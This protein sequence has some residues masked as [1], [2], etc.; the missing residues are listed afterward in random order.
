MGSC[1]FKREIRYKQV[2]LELDQ[3]SRY[4]RIGKLIIRSKN[5]HGKIIGHTSINFNVTEP[6]KISSKL[7]EVYN[8]KHWISSCVLPGLDPR[9]DCNKPCQDNCVFIENEK[10]I[11][12]AL[13]DGHGSDGNKV[14]QFCC[15]FAE[16]FFLEQFH[17][18]KVRAK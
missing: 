15:K 6:M 14:S 4:P 8:G 7:V 18:Y 1:V 2:P 5:S 17:S 9:G 12:L 11:L 10:S 13:F 16:N 3:I